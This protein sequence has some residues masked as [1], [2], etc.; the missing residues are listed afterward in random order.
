ME[1]VDVIKGNKTN[2]KAVTFEPSPP[3]K[4]RNVGKVQTV[5]PSTSNRG[6]KQSSIENFFS[7]NKASKKKLEEEND[8]SDNEEELEDELKEELEN[9]NMEE[10]CTDLDSLIE[11][12]PEICYLIKKSTIFT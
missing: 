7:K 10:V 11:T 4:G 9:E 2:K 3:S 5:K 6:K 12:G 8:N 1:M